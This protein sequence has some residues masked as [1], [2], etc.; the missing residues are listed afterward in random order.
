M[1]SLIF[2]LKFGV[3]QT[4]IYFVK[5]ILISVIVHDI[6]SGTLLKLQLSISHC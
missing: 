2:A 3:C 4:G 5:F 1:I 6:V